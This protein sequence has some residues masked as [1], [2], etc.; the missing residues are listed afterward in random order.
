MGTIASNYKGGLTSMNFRDLITLMILLIGTLGYKEIQH[1]K[2]TSEYIPKLQIHQH[3]LLIR[4]VFSWHNFHHW[5]SSLDLLVICIFKSSS[6]SNIL[7]LQVLF[8][9]KSSSSLDL[10]HPLIWIISVGSSILNLHRFYLMILLFTRSSIEPTLFHV[11]CRPSHHVGLCPA[12][13]YDH[14]GTNL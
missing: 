2:Y 14:A 10:D 13:T 12:L 8:F 7:H 6:S 9:F 1:I 4:K 3:S 11:G 5:S